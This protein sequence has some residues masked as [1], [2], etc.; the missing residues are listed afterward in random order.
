[1]NPWRRCIIRLLLAVLFLL[2]ALLLNDVAAEVELRSD[3]KFI[4]DLGHELED[5]LSENERVSE[6]EDLEIFQQ[7]P[8]QSE[9]PV[10]PEWSS[11][12]G[13]Y[14]EVEGDLIVE[15]DLGNE[16]DFMNSENYEDLYGGPE[17]NELPHCQNDGPDEERPRLV[18]ENFS[19]G[20]FPLFVKF[21]K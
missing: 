17:Y 4:L 13:D 5:E 7:V 19:R 9:T 8:R 15:D 6:D 11:V 1:M 16:S 3:H 10:F 18:K 2:F 21:T 20:I 14:D 12:E